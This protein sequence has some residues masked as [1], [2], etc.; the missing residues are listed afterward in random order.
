[1]KPAILSIAY[2]VLAASAFAQAQLP[3]AK[4]PALSPGNMKAYC[5]GE[6]SGMFGVRP[7]Y[8]NAGAVKKAKDGSFFIDGK[9]D[10]GKN[11]KK[12][13]R[14]RFTGKREFVDVMSLTNEGK[15]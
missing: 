5:R 14:C 4:G 11:G 6:A 2:F 15:L 13:F 7:R 10:Q 8:I 3:P 12:P 9:A 1:M